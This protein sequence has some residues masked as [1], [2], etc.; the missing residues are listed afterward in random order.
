MLPLTVD[1]KKC[2]FLH[3][4][5]ALNETIAMCFASFIR[6]NFTSA[7]GSAIL[8]LVGGTC[9]LP[10]DAQTRDVRV[11]G[12]GIRKCSEWQQWKQQSNG[13]VRA[14]ALEWASGF[15]SGHNVYGRNASEPVSSVVAESAVLATLLDSYCQ[16]NPESRILSGVMEITQSLGGMKTLVTPKKPAAPPSGENKAPRES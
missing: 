1:R 16:K 14:M 12:L 13:E 7:L 6:R 9:C 2:H 11:A 4:Q 15:I 5:P 10:A 3:R 8:V